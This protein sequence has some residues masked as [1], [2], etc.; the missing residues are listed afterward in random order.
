MEALKRFLQ[1]LHQKSVSCSKN[2]TR[3]LAQCDR[4]AVQ[5]EWKYLYFNSFTQ[6]AIGANTMIVD[7]R[8]APPTL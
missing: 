1:G 4:M 2:G 8:R 6:A 5:E 3:P 7:T